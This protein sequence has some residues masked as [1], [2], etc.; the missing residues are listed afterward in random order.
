MGNLTLCLSFTALFGVLVHRYVLTTIYMYGVLLSFAMFVCEIRAI[1]YSLGV[2]KNQST[3]AITAW[4]TVLGLAWRALGGTRILI[5]SIILIFLSWNLR[6]ICR[7]KQ[8]SDCESAASKTPSLKSIVESKE[9]HTGN[10]DTGNDDQS[11]VSPLKNILMTEKLSRQVKM[12]G[13]II[14]S[15]AQIVADIFITSCVTYT[16]VLVLIVIYLCGLTS[17]NVINAVYLLFLLYLS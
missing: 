10:D 12:Y 1:K 7:V 16:Y 14:A 2:D 6:C 3:S 4:P 8:D 17:V 15:T 5:Q 11:D 9:G 13:Y